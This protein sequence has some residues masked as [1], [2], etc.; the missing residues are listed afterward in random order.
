MLLNM[1][2]VA[3]KSRSPYIFLFAVSGLSNNG[4]GVAKGTV[5]HRGGTAGGP[6]FKTGDFVNG[7]GL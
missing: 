3:W 5:F 1:R 6:G 2:M 7:S 4:V